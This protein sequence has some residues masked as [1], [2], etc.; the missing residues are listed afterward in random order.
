MAIAP[1]WVVT[2]RQ[3]SGE[4]TP[5]TASQHVLQSPLPSSQPLSVGQAFHHPP[6]L[7]TSKYSI[8]HSSHVLTRLSR[9]WISVPL[10]LVSPLTSLPPQFPNWPH[11]W[12]LHSQ[13]QGTLQSELPSESPA[14]SMKSASVWILHSTHFTYGQTQ[15]HTIKAEAHFESHRGQ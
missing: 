6:E 11:L 12:S 1:R 3:R 5:L 15:T 13:A 8:N 10:W 2:P 4:H 7:G 14:L 9:V